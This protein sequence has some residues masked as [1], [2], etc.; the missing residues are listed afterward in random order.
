[1][2]TLH[3][4]SGIFLLIILLCFVCPLQGQTMMSATGLRLM[5]YN[6][7]NGNGM[8]GKHD[9]DRIASI[10]REVQPDVVAL[11]ELDSMTVRSGQVFVLQ[12]LAQQTGLHPTYGAAIPYGGGKYGIGVLS[13]EKPLHV[14][15]IPLPGREEARTLLIVEFKDYIWMATHLSLTSADQEASAEII[16]KEAAKAR[17]PV[18]LAGDMNSVPSSATQKMLRKT[19]VPLTDGE[20][21]T[22]DGRCIDYIYACRNGKTNIRV[23]Q[24]TLVDD[25]IASDHCPIWVDIQFI[26]P[27]N[28]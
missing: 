20:W 10:L 3:S 15:Q 16:R 6:I 13:K 4:I 27:K 11:Q 12:E 25:H 26:S 19:F 28:Q 5:S 7:R 17:K 1:M 21:Q 2:K 8:D 22:C 24:K 18:F 23:E 14:R 9:L